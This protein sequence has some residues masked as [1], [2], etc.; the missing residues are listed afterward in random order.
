MYTIVKKKRLINNIVA[1]DISAPRIAAKAK[2]GQFVIVIVKEGGERIPFTIA[3]CNEQE[4]T[5]KIIFQEIGA[6]T[7]LL[8]NLNE[9]ASVFA[10]AGPLGKPSHLDGYK[11][12]CVIGGGLGTAIAYP[13]ARYLHDNGTE[14][15]SVIGYRNSDLI[16]LEDEMSKVSD[17]L[18]I[19]T[20]DGSKGTKGFVTDVL[21]KL[22]EEG[23][24]Y[25]MVVA[26]GPLAMMRA[27]SNM[28]KEYGIKTTVSMNP[29]MID[30][31]GMCGGCRV[32]VGGETKFA[33]V[34]GPEFDGHEIDFDEA[35]KR[36]TIY[37]DYEAKHNKKVEHICR[38]GKE[39]MDA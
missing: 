24:V 27:V 33:C 5:V 9:E 11:K 28:T 22:I 1:M 4:G 26:I 3:E 17:K 23:N 29:I 14:V 8:G 31:T 36:Q 6:S 12:V 30:G 34:D 39:K 18:F 37:K 25:D 10:F 20:E 35:I 32:T 38:L 7:K 16:I 13:Q 15:H 19:A 21:R 2:P